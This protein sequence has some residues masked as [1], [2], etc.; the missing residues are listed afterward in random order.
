M[1]FFSVT[2]VTV[3]QLT[4]SENEFFALQITDNSFGKEK[5]QGR[6]CDCTYSLSSSWNPADTLQVIDIQYSFFKD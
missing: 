5:K 4:V 6:F 2:S 3:L 1:N